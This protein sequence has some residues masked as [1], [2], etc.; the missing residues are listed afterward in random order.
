LIIGQGHAVEYY[1]NPVLTVT[2]EEKL[3]AWH[4]TVIRDEH[5]QIVGTLSSGLDITEQKAAEEALQMT[6]FAV[7]HAGEATFWMGPDAKF[8]YVNEAACRALNYSRDEL[9]TM[10]VQDIDPDFPAAI[11]PQHWQEV[12]KNR[13]IR[14]E[15]RH[16]TK[17]GHIF[18]VE[19]T[20]NFLEYQGG[21]YMWAFARDI[22]ERKAA[23][24]M[25]R[26]TQFTVDHAGEPAFWM[27]STGKL[28]YVNDA[29]CKTL[30]Y[31]RDEMLQMSI[32]DLDPIFPREKW[33]EHWAES[34][35]KGSWRIE[36]QHRTKDGRLIPVEVSVNYVC[37]EGVEYHCSFA[38]DISERKAAEAAQKKLMRELQAKNEELEGIVFIASH[39]L[40]SPLVNIRGFTG[41]LEKSL[42]RLQDLLADEPLSSSARQQLEA[43][44]KADIDESMGFIKAG[45][46]KMDMLLNGL[47][48]LSRVGTAD[49]SPSELEM[50]QLFE[51]IVNSFRFRT[52]R[53]DIQIT[54]DQAI[55]DCR[56]DAVLVNQVFTNLIENA[57][58][59][60][61]PD[62][63]AKIHISGQAKNGTVVYCVRDNGIGIA[64]EHIEKVF[65]IFH[66]LNPDSGQSGEGLG[67]TIV[68]RIL[69]RQDGNIWIESEP[70]AGTSVYVELPNV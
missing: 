49:V 31:T 40:R 58:K 44:F 53:T 57:I 12:K 46:R 48:R 47:L 2:G 51:G 1:E 39:D 29:A 35:E 54:I 70:D 10:S 61:S 67:L 36:T 66:R 34:K 11:W 62:R 18:P 16:Q 33:G 69:K 13:T 3:I 8:M 30:G 15:S 41:E 43:M 25:L 6:Q 7:D 42:S 65:E 22:S 9:L 50:R 21:E 56:A 63:P 45:N 20:V 68:R 60:R 64:P 59:Y 27:D 23:E 26:F 38:R 24:E 55:P 4:N 28:T 19:I 17:D 14:F 32:P 37:Y 52:R 5:G